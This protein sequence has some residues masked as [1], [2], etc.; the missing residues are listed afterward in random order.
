MKIMDAQTNVNKT[1]GTGKILLGIAIMALIIAG[2]WNASRLFPIIPKTAT[3]LSV[4]AVTLFQSFVSGDSNPNLTATST[5]KSDDTASS[6]SKSNEV[7]TSTSIA[8]VPKSEKTDV[9]VTRPK[10]PV[11]TE[12]NSPV[13]TPTTNTTSAGP[14][15]ENTYPINKGTQSVSTIAKPDLVSRII[16]VGKIDRATNEFTATTSLRYSDRVAVRFEIKNEGGLESG[17]W[18]FSAV[19]PT[20]PNHIFNS[21]SQQSLK[22]G[23][24]IE[25]TIGFDSVLADQDARF[26]VNADPSQ[27]LSEI[28]EE[29]NIATTTV[30]ASS[31]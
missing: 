26:V 16:E 13:E 9:I 18:F 20:Y 15:T 22:P 6:T 14:K 4:A 24:K 30:R 2:A 23:D 10:D 29:N 17:Y 31:N 8:P 11:T 19:L 12:D 3:N 28:S 27:T 5:S 1:A 21:D 25:F 7:A